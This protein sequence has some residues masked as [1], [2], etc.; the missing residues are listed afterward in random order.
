MLTYLMLE[1]FVAWATGRCLCA[2]RPS[3]HSRRRIGIV[4]LLVV[5]ACLIGARDAN[6]DYAYSKS[7]TIDRTKVGA[8]GAPATLS[9]FPMLYSVTDPDLRTTANGGKVTNASGYDIVFR[10]ADGVT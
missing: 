6:A 10:A 1:P 9:N 8:T 4:A 5:A 2:D 3:A 7:I